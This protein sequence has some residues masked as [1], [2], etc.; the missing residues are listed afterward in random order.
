MMI[1]FMSYHTIQ[2]LPPVG[3]SSVPQQTVTIGMLIDQHLSFYDPSVKYTKQVFEA[4]TKN[5]LSSCLS[6]AISKY[7]IT[8]KD[9]F[10]EIH[11]P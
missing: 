1:L 11:I 2:A 10:I 5:D 4:G 8:S 7:F 3:Y 6:R 9:W